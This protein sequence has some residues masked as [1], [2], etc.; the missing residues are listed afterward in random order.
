MNIR[1]V[2]RR[3]FPP[4]MLD[5]VAAGLVN[6]WKYIY[7]FVVMGDLLLEFAL[8]GV[9]AKLP[10]YCPAEALPLIGRDRRIRR[11]LAE[12]DD[13]YAERLIGWLAAWRRAGSAYAIL[14]QLAAYIGVA[15]T[16]RIV[17]ANG[18]WWTRNPDGTR[19]RHVTLPTKN[20]DWDAHPELWARFWVVLYADDYGWTRD[21]TWGDGAVWGDDSYGWGLANLPW[22]EVADMRGIISEWK[23]AAAVCKNLIISFDAAYPDPTDSPGAPMPEGSWGSYYKISGGVAVPSR[24]LRLL[25]CGGA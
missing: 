10:G 9:R 7:S 25:F 4:W 15:G 16:L 2:A 3:F 22:Q 20:W 11:G 18:T 17:N 21:G 13:S 19:E 12:T 14:D 5:R 24:D 8:E 6:G 23:S 1:D